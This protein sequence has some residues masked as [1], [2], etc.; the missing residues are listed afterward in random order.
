[1]GFRDE[2]VQRVVRDFTPSAS[3]QVHLL[4][5]FDGVN[6]RGTITWR[7]GATSQGIGAPITEALRTELANCLA[8]A[9]QSITEISER[10]QLTR[11]L[12]EEVPKLERV[13][14]EGGR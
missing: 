5:K 10:A 4:I 11:Y 7:E 3:P 14:E 13:V 2:D 6:A 9:Q 8:L 1:M 12:A